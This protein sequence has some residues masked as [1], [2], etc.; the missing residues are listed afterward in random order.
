V[1]GTNLVAPM[2]LTRKA[3]PGMIAR[4]RG[5]VVN[6]ASLAGLS[7]T[8]FNEIYSAS[9]FGL[10]GFTRALRA[11]LQQDGSPVSAS[12]VCPGFV[13]GEGMFADQQRDAGVQPPRL[14]GFTT[15]EKVADAVVRAVE[16]DL[17]EV[18]V[19]PG[20][21]RP[22]LALGLLFPRLSEWLAP[23]IGANDVMVALTRSGG[24]RPR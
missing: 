23:R 24:V 13:V 16:R 4:G 6:V 1:I 9:K 2:R 18:V 7:V 12:A 21:M 22:L 8:A 10:V 3:L 11:S 19:N 17:P 15:P 14:I 5:H 20:P